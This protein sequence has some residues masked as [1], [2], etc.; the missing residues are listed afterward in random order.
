MP[1]KSGTVAA[2]T[3]CL[4]MWP[5]YGLL[6]VILVSSSRHMPGVLGVSSGSG[7]TVIPQEGR[8]WFPLLYLR[9]VLLHSVLCHSPLGSS[10]E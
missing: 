6:K 1:W 7:D 2:S 10:R 8:G 9:T 3:K 4:K 5:W